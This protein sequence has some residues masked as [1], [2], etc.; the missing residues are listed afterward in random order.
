MLGQ[1]LITLL[2]IVIAVIFLRRQRAQQRASTRAPQSKSQKA[3]PWQGRN[4][5]HQ[6]PPAPLDSRAPMAGKVKTVLW[7]VLT[8]IVVVGS[9]VTYL[10]WQDQQRL[11]T[12]LLYRDADQSPVIYRVSK[13][14]IG[15]RSFITEDG[16]QVTVSANERMEIVGL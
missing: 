9:L 10:Q 16:T 12:V 3:D 11:V 5:P 6:M 1:V 7:L 14:N 15:D 2:V 8:G 13:R 4:R